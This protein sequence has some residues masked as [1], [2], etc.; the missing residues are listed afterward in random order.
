LSC[1]V[2]GAE[3]VDRVAAELRQPASRLRRLDERPTFW[4]EDWISGM[5]EQR[6]ISTDTYIRY[7]VATIRGLAAV[8]RCILV[9]RGA[10]W[11]LPAAT[12]FRLRLIGDRADR[13]KTIA[14]V[15][16]L[17]ERDAGQLLDR[18]E[19]ERSEFVRRKFGA[20]PAEPHQYDLTLNSSR[21]SDDECAEMIVQAFTR[22]EGRFVNAE[23]L[24]V[25]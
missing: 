11:I 24:A 25:S 21:F 12:T 5:S 9:G 22:F 4:I 23:E 13:V 14:R 8:G 1:P 16:Q 18:T 17:S 2:Y 10:L 15:H 7:L 6:H 20:D 19:H 3:I